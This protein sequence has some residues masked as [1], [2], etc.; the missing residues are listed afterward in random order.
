MLAHLRCL[1]I[2]RAR[3]SL[4]QPATFS[5]AAASFSSSA[6]APTAGS[7]AAASPAEAASAAAAAASSDAVADLRGVPARAARRLSNMFYDE[8][9]QLSRRQQTVFSRLDDAPPLPPA[10]DHGYLHGFSADDLA[11]SSDAVRR[12]LSTRTGAQSDL[13]SFRTADTVRRFGATPRDTGAT[14]VQGSSR[15]RKRAPLLSR[16]K[17]HLPNSPR[18]AL[19]PTQWRC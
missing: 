16:A 13:R 9:V 2:V 15:E 3:C 1:A 6:G 14:R 18:R 8:S 4:V 5:A 10:A 17:A 19:S 7:R 12:A 11:S